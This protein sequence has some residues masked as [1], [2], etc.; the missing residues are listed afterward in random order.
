MNK[1]GHSYCHMHKH[2]SKKKCDNKKL[3]LIMFVLGAVTVMA[4]FL[5]LKCWVLILSCTLAFCGIL[6]LKSR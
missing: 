6:L 3:G 2:R 1:Y 5:P 4:I